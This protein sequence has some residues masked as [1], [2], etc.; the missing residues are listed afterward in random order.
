[1]AGLNS[2]R[3][4]AWARL[5]GKAEALAIDRRG[6]AAAADDKAW[7]VRLHGMADALSA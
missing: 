3:A 4:G 5:R 6:H 2:A 1:V 7:A